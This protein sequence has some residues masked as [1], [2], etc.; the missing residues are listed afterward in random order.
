MASQYLDLACSGKNQW[1]RYLAGISFITGL[2]IAA[3]IGFYGFLG[4]L[5][6]TAHQSPY[7]TVRNALTAVASDRFTEYV[8]LNLGHVVLLVGLIIAVRFIHK[9]R[10]LSL[11]TPQQKLDWKRIR[12]GFAVY[13]ALS[14]GMTLIDYALDPSGY[15]TT[16][17][18]V[19]V[20]I[21]A[22]VVLVL[23]PIQTTTEELLFRGYLMQ[24]AGLI[25]RRF[26]FP[27]A[28]T[29]LLF[30][31]LHLA[32]PEVQHGVAAASLYYFGIAFLFAAVTVKSN[33]LE[34]AIG[35]HAAI[36]LFA[37]LLVNY[38]DSALEIES[39]FFSNEVNLTA[40]LV[41]LVIMA[42]VSY[43]L[44]FRYGT[45]ASCEAPVSEES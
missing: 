10:F 31:V 35:A 39:V 28:M 23:T 6:E 45:R 1:W 5:M 7:P 18:P 29:S 43:L 37:A 19:Q 36:N 13:F 38:S 32:N 11:I 2:W 20:L 9:R 14:A 40:N 16:R 15:S 26:W 3:G 12:W 22:P 42:V 41:A 17:H 27:A 33:S 44:F 24:A 21:H 30:L 34:L 8:V 4:F 25:T